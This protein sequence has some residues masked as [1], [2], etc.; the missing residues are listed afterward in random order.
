MVKIL[1]TLVIIVGLG[2]GVYFIGGS[3]PP[4]PTEIATTTTVESEPAPTV[5]AIEPGVYALVPG[6]STITWS[7]KKPLIDG[8]INSGS[9]PV[10]SGT[11]EVF[12]SMVVSGLFTMDMN[13]L[14]VGLTAK[15][16]GK[17]SALEEHLKKADFFDVEQFPTSEFRIKRI[18]PRSDA[19][20][21][22]MYDLTGD[23]TIKGVTNEIVIPAVL[24]K[25]GD[26]M[27][28]RATFEIDRTLWG[29]T[30]GS[31]KFFTELGDNLIDDMVALELTIV[32]HPIDAQP[33]QPATTTTETSAT[34]SSP[35]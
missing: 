9:M 4:Q 17:E 1:I 20:T 2:V 31:G 26:T 15:K 13:D 22:F 28:A 34:T 18:A 12:D 32:G 19:S 21:T 29:I 11:I 23:L 25:E 27:V 6:E 14:T 3:T 8:Y 35:E 24:Q 33:T 7:A 16:P 5:S 10:A 30:L